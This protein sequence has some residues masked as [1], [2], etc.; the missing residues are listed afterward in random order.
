MVHLGFGVLH[1]QELSVL[2]LVNTGEQQPL[3][4][5]QIAKPG[6]ERGPSLVKYSV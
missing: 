5:T 6:A 3:L 4:G 1:W 2:S